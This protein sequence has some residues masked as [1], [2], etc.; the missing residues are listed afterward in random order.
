MIAFRFVCVIAIFLSTCRSLSGEQLVQG[1]VEAQSTTQ[2][3]DLTEDIQKFRKLWQENPQSP[4]AKR[5]Y[6]ELMRALED[7]MKESKLRNFELKGKITDGLGNDID[8]VRVNIARNKPDVG[9]RPDD[10][11]PTKPDMRRFEVSGSFQI[12]ERGYSHLAIHFVK[13]G[14]YSRSLYIDDNAIRD[15]V[16]TFRILRG[17]GTSV[18]TVAKDNLVVVLRKIGKPTNLLSTSFSVATEKDG[19][20]TI[21]DIPAPEDVRAWKDES[22]GRGSRKIARDAEP[23]S[24]YIEI[25]WSGKFIE[26][27]DVPAKYRS[28]PPAPCPEAVNIAMKGIEGGFVLYD[29][30]DS[31]YAVY[32]MFEAPLEG[33][34]PTMILTFE[35]SARLI[36]DLSSLRFYVR[37]GK[38]YGRGSFRVFELSK[39][40]VHVL[41]QISIQPDG[42]RNLENVD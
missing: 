20:R 33:Y 26:A 7:R 17:L 2:P 5:K 6:F 29:P 21:C 12:S 36:K 25:T 23:P 27:K 18:P 22:S 10:A 31:D 1:E 41:M 24:S 32:E 8:G 13:E 42:S 28:K 16:D 11:K 19:I 3:A 14:Y 40:Q 37:I 34:Q 15:E 38:V 39:G 4:E 9:F 35:N 30:K